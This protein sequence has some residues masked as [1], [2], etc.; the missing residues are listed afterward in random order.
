MIYLGIA[1]ALAFAEPGVVADAQ[2]FMANY[3][4]ILVA[5]DK[6]RLLALYD[7]QGTY[8]L[9]DGTKEFRSPAGMADMYK[10]WGGPADFEWHDLSYEP[11]G[12]DA[13]MVLGR[14]TWTP[15]SGRPP[16]TLSYS[17]LLV[18]RDGKLRIRVEDESRP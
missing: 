14:F 12:K 2:R 7:P 13:V 3:R 8:V 6:A 11:V 17:S 1:S 4:T 18:R 5:G 16:A 9:G 10:N 15:K